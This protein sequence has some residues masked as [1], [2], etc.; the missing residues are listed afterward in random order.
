[1][2]A[3]LVVSGLFPVSK[4]ENNSAVGLPYPKMKHPLGQLSMACAWSMGQNAQS[5]PVC[6]TACAAASQIAEVGSKSTHP[7][8]SHD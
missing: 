7:R 8:C 5:E 3:P 1:M 2:C 6:P 4:M